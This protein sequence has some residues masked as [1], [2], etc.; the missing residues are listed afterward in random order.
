M[1]SEQNAQK[2]MSTFLKVLLTL[3]GAAIVMTVLYVMD[4]AEY[5]LFV[6][7]LVIDIVGVFQESLRV[8]L[9]SFGFLVLFLFAGLNFFYPQET[10]SNKTEISKT[11]SANEENNQPADN[12]EQ[13]PSTEVLSLDKILMS[14]ISSSKILT[15]V[16][17]YSISLITIGFLIGSKMRDKK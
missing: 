13:A 16:A 10:M 4:L 11:S 15:A 2:E 1:S 7:F 12:A 3:F 17:I 8:K 6:T 5:F 14:V 9:I